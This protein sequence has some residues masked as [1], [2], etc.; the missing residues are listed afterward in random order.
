LHGL[1]G[2]GD[3]IEQTTLDCRPVREDQRQRVVKVEP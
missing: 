1:E 3:Q 2:V